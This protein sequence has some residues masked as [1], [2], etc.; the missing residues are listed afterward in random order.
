MSRR[1]LDRRGRRPLAG[2]AARPHRTPADLT[3]RSWSP[4][5]VIHVCYFDGFYPKAPPLPLNGT[6]PPPFDRIV[7]W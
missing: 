5:D 2:N 7:C 4:N 3:I 6:P 1:Q